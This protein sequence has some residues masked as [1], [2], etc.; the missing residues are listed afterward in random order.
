MAP[1]IAPQLKKVEMLTRVTFER[2]DT[3]R[4]CGDAFKLLREV[5]AMQFVQSR[6]SIPLPRVLDTNIIENDVKDQSW[7]IM[8]RL[9]GIELGKA[10]PGMSENARAR[11]IKEL[12]SY[13]EQLHAIRPPA[14]ETA[15]IGSCSKGPAY[16]HRLNNMSTC[17]PWASVGEFHDFLVGPVKASP[18]PDWVAKF[19]CKLP[20]SHNITFAH[21]DLSW[22]NILVEP[23]SGK[24]TGILDWEM[25][26]FWPRWWEYRKAL[27]GARSQ[28]WWRDILGK[29]TEEYREETDNDMDLEMF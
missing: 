26:G 17:G 24:V 14:H 5:E 11:T 1:S 15:W 28:S 4:K 8:E 9:A 13:L 25:A 18:R 21:A 3:I 22:E 10:W 12:Q 23:D 19:R 29:I 7:I 6:T 2:T 20:D 27:Y 16:D